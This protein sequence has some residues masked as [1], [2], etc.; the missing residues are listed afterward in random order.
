[1]I[2]IYR[3]GYFMRKTF[4]KNQVIKYSNRTYSYFYCM[5]FSRDKLIKDWA[6]YSCDEKKI[7]RFS[8]IN[9]SKIFVPQKFLAS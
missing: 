7:C 9:K 4:L 8:K 2:Y 6:P 5:A 3:V 1:M